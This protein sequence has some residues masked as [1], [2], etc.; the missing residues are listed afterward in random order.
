MIRLNEEEMI[1]IER[2][3]AGPFTK[4]CPECYS[5]IEAGFTAYQINVNKPQFRDDSDPNS[6]EKNYWSFLGS[7][8][9]P[10]IT[11]PVSFKGVTISLAG[12]NQIKLTV[13]N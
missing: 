3:E 5:A 12:K 4:I 13:S 2:R 8:T 11:D 1:V 7:R 9:D 10:T 6:D